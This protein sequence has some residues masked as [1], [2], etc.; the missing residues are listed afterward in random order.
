MLL[1]IYGLFRLAVFIALVYG[2]VQF[3]RI[4]KRAIKA[5]DIYLKEHRSPEETE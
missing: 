4:A 2:Y 1:Y 5:L 3:I